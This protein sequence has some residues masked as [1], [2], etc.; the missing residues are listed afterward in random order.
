V[1]WSATPWIVAAVARAGG[2]VPFAPGGAAGRRARSHRPIWLRAV[3]LG[4]LT[5]VVA[6]VEPVAALLP[7]AVA[8]LLAFGG[9]LV[10]E[11]A[12]GG[13]MLGA[14]ATAAAVAAV[15]HLPWTLDLVAPGSVWSAITRAQAGTAMA[16]DEL[17]RFET[18]PIGA[19]P[20]GYVFLLAGALPLLIGRAWRLGWA[21]RCWTL[22]A[23]GWALAVVDGL[24]VMPVSLGPVELLLAPAACG[25]ALATGL[26][27]VAFEVDLRD[28]RFGW[29]QLASFGAA[30]AVLVGAVPIVTGSL[31]GDWGSPRDGIGSVL[32]FLDAE[33]ES[34]GPFRTLWLGDPSVLPLHGWQLEEGLAWGLTDRGLPNVVDRWPGSPRR[35]AEQIPDLLAVAG[36]GETARL[37]RQLAPFGVRYIVVVEA[38]RPVSG[39]Q[40]EVPEAVLEAFG[41]QLDLAELGVDAGVHV[42]RNVAWF[43]SRA[44]L[45]E[46]GVAAASGEGTAGRGS[47]EAPALPDVDGATRYTG[48]LEIGDAV[49]QAASSAS[50]WSLEVAGEA[51]DRI[52]GFGFGNLFEPGGA[53]DEGGSATLS[54]R[55]PLHR[56]AVSGLQAAAW[57]VVVGTCWRR[58][59]RRG[60][61][62]P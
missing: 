21:V 15:L 62:A 36:G 6:A 30:A 52:E 20:I 47:A 23:G 46:D 41:S 51:R 28:F 18:G 44:V 17:L 13:R 43:P 24:D 50:G 19:A 27:M 5:A 35:A 2:Q 22:A 12:G 11:R 14:G 7:L 31:D 3:P 1:A 4:L 10:G 57:V 37:G 16:V 33:Q 61:E 45:T 49:W 40:V 32:G 25:L 60:G 54:Y 53:G 8:A 59:A 26:G 48:D 58:R 34:E 9:L 38:D 56:L 29:R 42:Y 39:P 55:T